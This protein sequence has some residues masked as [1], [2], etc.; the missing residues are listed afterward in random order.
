M[1]VNQSHHKLMYLPMLSKLLD[2]ELEQ[3]TDNEI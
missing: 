1:Q 2:L 3:K